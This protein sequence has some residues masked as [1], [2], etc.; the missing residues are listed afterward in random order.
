MSEAGDWRRIVAALSLEPHPEGGYWRETHRDIMADGG[1][2]SVTQIYYLLPSGE[3]SA[4][5]RITDATEIWH[6]QSGA[7]L[8]LS[9][10][11]D[12]ETVDQYLLGPDVLGGDTGHVIVPAGCWQSA[13]SRGAW[14]LVGCTVAPAF[15][16]SSF[17]MA[18]AGWSPGGGPG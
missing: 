2:G 12:G 18:P 13:E 1:R 7:P 8:T 10:S 11:H 5:H 3:T 16:F 17:E 4:W 14:T 15:T 6:Y 9:L